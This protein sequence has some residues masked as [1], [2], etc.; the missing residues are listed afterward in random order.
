[1]LADDN[2]NRWR[3]AQKAARSAIE[4]QD[5][6]RAA[7]HFLDAVGEAEQLLLHRAED[8]P[9]P[10]MYIS[11]CNCL[12]ETYRQLG[13][14]ELAFHAMRQAHKRLIQI[15]R[16][17][18]LPPVL[19]HECLRELN[20]CLIPIIGVLRQTPEGAVEAQRLL[21]EAKCLAHNCFQFTRAAKLSPPKNI[22]H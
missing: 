5:L 21:N 2:L 6:A 12:A 7:E 17:A 1:M 19:R 15:I 4:S 18:A 8:L 14:E 16:D 13:R 10:R 20:H 22:R 9:T 11:S 3:D